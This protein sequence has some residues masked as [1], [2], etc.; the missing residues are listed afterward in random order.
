MNTI[1]LAVLD[2]AGTTV[3][4]PD[5]VASC[6]Q[7]ALT[8]VGVE[9]SRQEANAVMGIPKPVAIGMLLESKDHAELLPQVPAIYEDFAARMSRYYEDCAEIEPMPGTEEALEKMRAAGIKIVLDTGFSRPIT[10]LIVNKLGW[11][12]R[13]IDASVSA[14]DV[15]NG[16]PHPDLIFKA[17]EIVGVE[18]VNEVLKAGDT[19]SDL[20]EGTAAGCAL[21]VGVTTGTHTEDE[22]RAH[23]HTHLVPAVADLPALL[24]L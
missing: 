7:G 11:Q 18:S 12:G 8:S 16:R 22:L 15:A 4:D 2:I 3:K 6:L 14:D 24:R 13:L 10:D 20:Q 17:M 23:P 5:A 21:V 1:R 19:P 9:I